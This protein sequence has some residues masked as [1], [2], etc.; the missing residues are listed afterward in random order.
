MY[1]ALET[2][3]ADRIHGLNVM[4]NVSFFYRLTHA[5]SKMKQHWSLHKWHK[6]K[7]NISSSGHPFQEYILHSVET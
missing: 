2:Q 6:T 4:T 1:F 5:D 7:L 3:N